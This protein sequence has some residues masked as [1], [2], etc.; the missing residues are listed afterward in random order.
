MATVTSGKILGLNMMTYLPTNFDVKKSYP[1]LIFL[2]G[3]GEIG[4]SA[5]LLL[6]HGPF[7]YLKSGVDLGLDLIVIAIQNV[8]ANPRPSEV[9]SYIDAIKKLY[10]ISALIGTGLSR[11]GQDWDWYVC[12]S[13]T[14]LAQMS[15]LVMFS[16]QGPVGDTPGIPGTWSP[17]LFQKH[18]VK[19]WFG[20]GTAD[21]FY[22]NNKTRCNSLLVLDKTLAAWTEWPGVGHSDPVWADGYNPNWTN[23]SLKQSIYTYSSK[24]GVSSP[25]VVPPPPVTVVYLSAAATETFSKSNCTYGTPTS[26]IYSV[27]AGKYTSSVSQAAADALAVNDVTINGQAYANA[28]GSCTPKLLVTLQ[29]FDNGTFKSI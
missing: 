21:P 20:I 12:N 4:T 25:I 18:G 19:Y 14:Q 5:S 15:A 11:G 1:C 23:N 7:Q 22:A 27:P 6:N 24:F 2:P 3:A 13:E 8:N 9:Q 28:N 26:V 16:S 17:S 10:N 29:I